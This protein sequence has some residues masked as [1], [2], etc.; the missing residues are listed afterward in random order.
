MSLHVLRSRGASTVIDE[1][2]SGQRLT[3][4][5]LEAGRVVAHERAG[6]EQVVAVLSGSLDVDLVDDGATLWAGDVAIIPGGARR[7]LVTREPTVII[8]GS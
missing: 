4:T 7:A 8:V 6:D 5:E 1:L 3:V 2:W